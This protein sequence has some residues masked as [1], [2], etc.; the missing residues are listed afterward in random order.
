MKPSKVMTLSAA[1]WP[2]QSQL[3]FPSAYSEAAPSFGTPVAW[4]NPGNIY[5]VDGLLATATMAPASPV[6]TPN[7]LI[8]KGYGFDLPDD[9]IVTGIKL[10][11]WLSASVPFGYSQASVTKNGSSTAGTGTSWDALLTTSIEEY[12]TLAPINPLWGTTWT[13]AEINSA[14]FG[15]IFTAFNSDNVNVSVNI[16][17]LAIEVFYRAPPTPPGDPYWFDVA[18]LLHLNG[19]GTTIVDQKGGD[20]S[21]LG[22]A[23]QDSTDI[24]Y[25]GNTLKVSDGAVGSVTQSIAI[26]TGDFTLEVS[27][28]LNNKQG[29]AIFLEAYN[30]EASLAWQLYLEGASQCALYGL[31]PNV[32][33]SSGFNTA[34]PFA[35]A[36]SR[37]S[38]V[39]RM[40]VNGAKVAEAS[41]TTDYG[42]LYAISLG[43]PVGGGSDRW[44]GALCELRITAGV[45]RY[46]GETCPVQT[47]PFPDN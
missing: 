29:W 23:T 28:K 41:D 17:A 1:P 12:T 44:G 9:A 21:A 24:I 5:A 16:D 22:D 36:I 27:G 39:T 46:A 20:W 26:G 43:Q 31:G 13:P 7:K 34:N 25:G 18:A 8:A 6:Q 14:N 45:G 11:G 38:G 37:V 47:G 42:T 4:T 10:Y 2:E 35:L 33:S 3:R 30:T 15:Q 32:I 19:T 40:Y